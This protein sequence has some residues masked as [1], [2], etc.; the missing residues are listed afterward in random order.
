MTGSLRS[1]RPV[2]ATACHGA[3]P[4]AASGGRTEGGSPC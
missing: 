3:A 4:T 1:Y 2:V